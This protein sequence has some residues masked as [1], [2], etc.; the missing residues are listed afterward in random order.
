MR[1]RCGPFDLTPLVLLLVSSDP[2]R[3]SVAAPSCK[4]ADKEIPPSDVVHETGS[5]HGPLSLVY[6]VCSKTLV[7]MPLI[8]IHASLICAGGDAGVASVIVGLG[9][10]R[11][12]N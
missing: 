9:A 12:P 6:L 5:M 10:P 8:P 4:M 11:A 1:Q 2:R 7:S 3:T